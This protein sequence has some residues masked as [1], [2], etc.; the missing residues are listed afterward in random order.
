MCVGYGFTRAEISCGE[1]Q[2][3]NIKTNKLNPT[4]E[5]NIQQT[6]EHTSKQKQATYTNPVEEKCK[7]TEKKEKQTSHHQRSNNNDTPQER[8]RQ[9][10]QQHVTKRREHCPSHKARSHQF[11][12][13]F[14][15]CYS[16]HHV[17]ACHLNNMLS[18]LLGMSLSFNDF[19]HE[20]IN[21]GFHGI[22]SWCS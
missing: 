5:R 14:V 1:K 4:E 10:Q 15:C 7:C 21:I 18:G 3:T 8:K 16:P 11:R 9:S 17:F 2:T 13:D 20:L 12:E 6:Q 19:I 22:N